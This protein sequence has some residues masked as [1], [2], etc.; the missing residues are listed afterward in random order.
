MKATLEFNLPEEEQHQDAIHGSDYKFVIQDL[1][2]YLRAKVK[3]AIS[4]TTF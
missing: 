2:S 3:Y 1:D 4:F